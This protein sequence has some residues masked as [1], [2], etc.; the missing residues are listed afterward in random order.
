[1]AGRNIRLCRRAKARGIH[2]AMS[3]EIESAETANPSRRQAVISDASSGQGLFVFDVHLLADPSSSLRRTRRAAGWTLAWQKS[4]PSGRQ[5]RAFEDVRD[6]SESGAIHP[7][8]GLRGP[9]RFPGNLRG[10]EHLCKSFG[11]TI[12]FKRGE[13]SCAFYAE[14]VVAGGSQSHRKTLEVR[15]FC[16]RVGCF[17]RCHAHDQEMRTMMVALKLRPL[18]FRH[19][20]SNAKAVHSS[21]S[22]RRYCR[23]A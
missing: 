11:V 20:L 1:M 18:H 5:A 17:P 10:P 2:H 19:V 6:S 13:K 16:G 21:M 15:R 12:V 14:G 7:R 3:R 22:K 8:P 23:R 4:S 9:F